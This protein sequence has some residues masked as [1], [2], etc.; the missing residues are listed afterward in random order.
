M[1]ARQN[2]YW[3]SH[4]QTRPLCGW[5]LIPAS[6]FGSLQQ[7]SGSAPQTGQAMSQG[8][9]FFGGFMPHPGPGA[10]PAALR[11]SPPPASSVEA[12]VHARQAQRRSDGDVRRRPCVGTAAEPRDIRARIVQRVGALAEQLVR[13]G[14]AHRSTPGRGH[15]RRRVVP[16]RNT[17]GAHGYFRRH[18]PRA[19]MTARSQRACMRVSA[20]TAAPIA[21]KYE[22]RRLLPLDT[23]SSPLPTYPRSRYPP[24][25]MPELPRRTR[26]AGSP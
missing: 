17:A 19:G 13:H 9:G 16:R 11:G 10:I 26:I 8:L 4:S 2:S 6:L 21:A 14:P 23:H 22:A 24:G 7:R 15:S 3:A 5:L 18:R 25:A 12:R 1:L 20:R